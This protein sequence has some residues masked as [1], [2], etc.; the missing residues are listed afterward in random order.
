ME[1]GGWA[2]EVGG[3]VLEVGFGVVAATSLTTDFGG[4]SRRRPWHDGWRILP[5]EVHSVDSTSPTHSGRTQC[6]FRPSQPAG[7]GVNGDSGTSI[8]FNCRRRSRAIFVVKPVPT[9]PART[10]LPPA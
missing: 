5:S 3:W 9:L 6:A 2:L 8:L 7:G 4:L 10:R 1:L